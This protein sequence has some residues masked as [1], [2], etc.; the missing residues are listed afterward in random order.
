MRIP[1]LP[2]FRPNKTWLALGAALGI[3]IV[4][5]VVARSYL[6]NRLAEIDA[7]NRGKMVSVIVAKKEL[8]K[9]DRISEDTVAVRPIPL[10]YVHSQAI[11]PD[12]FDR[13]EGQ[14]LAF[15][16]KPGEMILWS[17]LEGKKV[18]TFSTRVAAGHRAITVPV[19]EINSISG[20]L[21][22]GD[23]VDL[24]ATVDRGERKYT[25]VLLQSIPVLATGQRSLDDPKSG[26][27]RLYSTVTLDATP[28]EAQKI[29]RGRE[30]GKLTALLRNPHDK[31]ALPTTDIAA[32]FAGDA[33]AAAEGGGVPVLYGGRS[34]A[35]PPE[36]LRLSQFSRREPPTG[37]EPALVKSA[38]V[39]A[40]P[41]FPA[42]PAAGSADLSV[43]TFNLRLDTN[44]P[45]TP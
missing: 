44:R 4:A 36:G 10:D 41:A 13:V 5:A 28:E 8:G 11:P 3:G 6:S 34:G 42:P 35:L 15:P 16:V 21:E 29:I 43:P 33:P 20:M 31:A 17:L 25:F 9:G 27:R 39:V 12:N 24:I 26:E 14:P 45:T 32:L 7:H 37:P 22:P 30:S 19:D 23:M 18:P 1:K 40:T 2:A 38:T